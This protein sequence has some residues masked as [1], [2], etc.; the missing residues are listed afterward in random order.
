MVICTLFGYG[1]FLSV[2]W[3]FPQ[4]W[5]IPGV[6]VEM[7]LFA[8]ENSS[9]MYGKFQCFLH[10]S[11]RCYGSF[12]CIGG[13]D[14]DNS[15]FFASYKSMRVVILMHNANRLPFCLRLSSILQPVDDVSFHQNFQKNKY[16]IMHIVLSLPPPPWFSCMTCVTKLSLVV[17]FSSHTLPPT[18]HLYV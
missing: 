3:K 13:R 12:S 8:T 4:Q 17:D 10:S 1:K 14:F 7:F 9:W 6:S 5:E 15:L 2:V 18:T 16:Q 11:I